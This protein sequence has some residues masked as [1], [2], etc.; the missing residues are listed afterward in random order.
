MPPVRRLAKLARPARVA[1]AL[2]VIASCSMGGAG[3][4]EPVCDDLCRF[5]VIVHGVVTDAGGTP[6]AGAIVDVRAFPWA[7]G[8]LTSRPIALPVGTSAAVTAADGGY[9]HRYTATAPPV[10]LRVCLEVRATPP[11]SL[12]EA[13]PIV[14][15]GPVV[16]LL[17]DDGRRALDSARV[18]ITL[19]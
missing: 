5:S 4:A 19:P 17:L 6:A 15:A 9:R 18:D 11:A 10:N 1:L 2:A 12:P 14:V 8:C 13:S 16:R 3:P 7:D